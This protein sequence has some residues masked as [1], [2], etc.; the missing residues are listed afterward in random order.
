MCV[1]VCVCERERERE[2]D[3]NKGQVSHFGLC[4]SPSSGWR[5]GVWAEALL[6]V[7]FLLG[8]VV[9]HKT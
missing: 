5:M 8:V 4:F 6:R 3:E 9:G 2:N 7:L 1:C